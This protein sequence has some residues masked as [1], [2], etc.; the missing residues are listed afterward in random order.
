MLSVA[1]LCER[2]HHYR[3]ST[4]RVGG[5]QVRRAKVVE[6]TSYIEYMDNYDQKL[7]QK[8]M[9]QAILQNPPRDGC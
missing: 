4:R 9:V 1:E 8:V 6:Q 7:V 2:H 3:E 5:N